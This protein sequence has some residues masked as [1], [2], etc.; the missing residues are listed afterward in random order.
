MIFTSGDVVLDPNKAIVHI[1]FADLEE[2]EKFVA[3]LD[4]MPANH[5]TYSIG[6]PADIEALKAAQAKGQPKNADLKLE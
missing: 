6:P 2:R 4:A 3:D 5:D 1:R